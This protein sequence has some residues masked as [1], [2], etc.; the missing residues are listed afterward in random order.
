MPLGGAVAIPIVRSPWK[1][2]ART[3][4]LLQPGVALLA[5]VAA[6]ACGD[7]SGGDSPKPEREL[8]VS[9][10]ASLTDVMAEVET[11]FEEAHPGVDVE[12]NLAGSSTLSVQ[13]LEGAPVDV[14]ASA[15]TADMDRIV[16]AGAVAGEPRVFARN[17]LRIAV[18]EGNPAG[19]EGL[20]DF[21]D[22]DLLLGLCAEVVPCGALAREALRRAG[23]TPE[24]DTAE[25]DV[26]ALLTRVEAGE[27]DAGITYVTDVASA[28]DGVD[29][30]DLPEEA[31]V[32]ADYPIAV[33]RRTDRP[34]LARA[35]VAFVRSERGRA[36][37]T[38]HGFG[39]P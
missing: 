5:A 18:P 22:G 25:P 2:G 19:I 9:A 10:A 34:E 12:L 17:R 31:N 14:F 27:L 3:R 23:V 26:R 16:E 32:A 15:S 28:E 4:S 13:I 36:I 38:R 8:L 35:F 30:V 7:T 24:I 11:A 39:A 21:A 1:S 33:L 20:E 37:L 6:I 29:G